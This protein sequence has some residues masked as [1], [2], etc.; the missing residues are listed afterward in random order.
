[1]IL[2]CKFTLREKNAVLQ[3]APHLWLLD[4]AL[5]NELEYVQYESQRNRERTAWR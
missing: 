4:M 2:K 1:M 5:E 3:Y